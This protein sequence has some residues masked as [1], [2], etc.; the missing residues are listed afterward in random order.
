MKKTPWIKGAVIASMAIMS[1]TAAD[2][3]WPSDGDW[4]ALRLGTNYYY[5]AEGDINPGQVDLIGTTDTY[6]AGY[7]GFVENG[8][9]NGPSLDDAFMFR[10]RV[11]GESG[12]Y[13]WQTHLDTDGDATNVEWIFQ[14]VQSGSNDGVNLIKTAVGGATL[15][16]VDIG[17]NTVAWL[18]DL[19]LYSRWTA[20]D[21]STHFHV[22]F[23]VPWTEFRSITGVS[24]LEQI[25]V[26]LSTST[27]HANVINGDAPLG[28]N[29]SEQISNVLSDNIPEPAVATL[30]FGAG[31]GIV[32]YRRIF[33]PGTKSEDQSPE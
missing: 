8:Y 17:S 10:M 25:R 32:A 24:D 1:N 20:V 21:S 12:N 4:T 9:V 15:N 14:L 7:W 16:D 27:T 2:I 29:L 19:S 3:I 23:A 30:L 6:S 26:V 31:F 33:N 22:D 13:V 5:D 18:G 11:G 28:I